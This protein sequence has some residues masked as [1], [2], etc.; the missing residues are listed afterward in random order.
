M[1]TKGGHIRLHDKLLVTAIPCN[2]LKIYQHS[3][4]C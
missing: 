2:V 3:F 4:G 1:A